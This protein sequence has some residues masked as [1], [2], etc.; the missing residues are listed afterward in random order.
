M[1]VGRLKRRALTFGF[2]PYPRS[3]AFIRVP[4]GL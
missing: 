4:F 1:K 2:K 3:S